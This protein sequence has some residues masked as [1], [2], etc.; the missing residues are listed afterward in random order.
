MTDSEDLCSLNCDNYLKSTTRV[1]HTVKLKLT[2][3]LGRQVSLVKPIW[4]CCASIREYLWQLGRDVFYERQTRLT[5]KSSWRL[6]VP[7]LSPASGHSRRFLHTHTHTHTRTHTHT[8]T[9][10]RTHTHTRTRTHAQTYA[11]TLTHTHAHTHT[12][13]QIFF[14]FLSKYMR[15]TGNITA[16][17]CKVL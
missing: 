6:Q 13:R 3:R 17:L 16:E 15:H 2:G 12:H 11:H 14:N 7:C 5:G 8:H 4:F 1:P 9:R 10:T